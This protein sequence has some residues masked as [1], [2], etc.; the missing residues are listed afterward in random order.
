ME[1]RINKSVKT[2]DVGYLHLAQ[3]YERIKRQEDRNIYIDF[4]ICQRFDA[5]LAAVLGALLDIFKKRG[6]DVWLRNLNNV[7]V[8]RTLFRNHFL[9][10]FQIEASN[11]EKESFIPYGRFTVSDTQAFKQYIK[12]ELIGKQRFPKHTELVEK[13]IVESIYEIYANAI[14][15]GNCDYVYCCGEYDADATLPT[16]NM[17]I[18]DCGKTIHQNVK[19]FLEKQNKRV[20]TPL[21]S[22]SWAFEEGHTTKNIPGGLGLSLIREFV[23]LNKGSLQVVS[24]SG[25]L[26]YRYGVTKL[27]ELGIPF[28][29]T[30]VNMEFN[31]N[32]DKIYRMA[33]EDIDI[34]NL[35]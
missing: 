6:C 16:L 10:A 26:D 1:Y 27:I 9:K 17:T 23:T 13:N 18:V 20:L 3:L 15:H 7:G 35:L 30:I 4:S 34:N 25:M 33:N 11:E 2:N 22:I 14:S 32:D 19:S 12:D 8:R 29:G 5:N 28:P 31:F 21:E 24:S